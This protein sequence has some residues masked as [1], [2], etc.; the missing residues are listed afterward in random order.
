[1]QL[2][3]QYTCSGAHADKHLFLTTDNN[4]K[5]I[6]K[7]LKPNV[8]L[9]INHADTNSTANHIKN[10]ADISNLCTKLDQSP[11]LGN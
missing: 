4:F 1:M 3:S 9:K 5:P 10:F 7:N 2:T 8:F 11:H 6:A